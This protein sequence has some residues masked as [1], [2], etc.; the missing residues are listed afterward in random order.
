VH[1]VP[2]RPVP[3]ALA[4]LERGDFTAA[5]ALRDD[6]EMLVTALDGIYLD[7]SA[8]AGPEN[9]PELMA[10]FARARAANALLAALDSDPVKA[11]LDAIYEAHA[12]L[13]YDREGKFLETVKAL[14]RDL[15]A[16]A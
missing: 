5:L 2:D 6:V 13:A 15:Q 1:P 11:A 4:A 12:S 7:Q 8:A 16:G 9:D 10:A 14:L 3:Q